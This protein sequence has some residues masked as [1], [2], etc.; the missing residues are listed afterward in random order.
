MS[1]YTIAT[2]R[3]GPAPL[4]AAILLGWLHREQLDA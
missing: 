2:S 4:M 1:D 3:R